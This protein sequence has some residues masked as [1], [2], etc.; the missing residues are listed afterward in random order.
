MFEDVVVRFEKLEDEVL[1][2]S[3]GMF[4]EDAGG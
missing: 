1:V 2:N 3:A 4:D